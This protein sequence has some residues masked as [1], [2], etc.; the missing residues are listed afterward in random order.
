[1][2]LLSWNMLKYCVFSEME[3]VM[4]YFLLRSREEATLGESSTSA[5]S[6]PS[7]AGKEVKAY[8]VKEKKSKHGEK[9]KR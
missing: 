8:S 2:Y 4:F 3:Y 6:Q 7:T 1:M 9:R 5:V